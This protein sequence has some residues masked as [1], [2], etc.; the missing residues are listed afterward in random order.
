[1]DSVGGGDLLRRLVDDKHPHLYSYLVANYP[2]SSF[3]WVS[4]VITPVIDMGFLEGESTEI[5]GLI[6]HLRFV[7]WATKYYLPCFI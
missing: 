6:S 5:T 4:S 1:M 7:G 3:L 2:R